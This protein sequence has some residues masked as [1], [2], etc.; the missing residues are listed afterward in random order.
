LAPYF[1]TTTERRDYGAQQ[2]T[3]FNVKMWQCI[4]FEVSI[5]CLPSPFFSIPSILTRLMMGFYFTL[6]PSVAL[7]AYFPSIIFP[8]YS[9]FLFFKPNNMQQTCITRICFSFEQVALS[10]LKISANFFLFLLVSQI[11]LKIT[12]PFSK[13]VSF[14][15]KIGKI[16]NM[17][18]TFVKNSYDTFL[19]FR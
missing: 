7:C 9:F 16:N 3:D 2:V 18:W 1:S 15:M 19:L 13:N 12:Q 11:S 14:V 5:K 8:S 4:C 17:C 6:K 10:E